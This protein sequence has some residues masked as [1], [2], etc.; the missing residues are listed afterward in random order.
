[1]SSSPYAVAKHTDLE[2]FF[3][4]KIVSLSVHQTLLILLLPQISVL[5]FPLPQKVL[6]HFLATRRSGTRQK[7]HNPILYREPIYFLSLP[8]QCFYFFLNNPEKSQNKQR[9]SSYLYLYAK[10]YFLMRK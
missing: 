9:V 10:V 5:S 7:Q 2:H 8:H 4:S 6:W 1:M 3:R